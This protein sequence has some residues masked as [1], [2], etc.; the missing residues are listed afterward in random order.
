MVYAPQN[1]LIV[2]SDRSLL[3]EVDNPL[4]ASARDDLARFAELEKSPEHIHTY[5]IT[6]LSL[7][8]AASAGLTPEAA[9]DILGKYS[10]FDLPGNVLI[11]IKDYINRFGRLKLTKSPEGDL[12]LKSED[13]MLISEVSRNKRIAPHAVGDRRRRAQRERWSRSTPPITIR[14]GMMKRPAPAG[15]GPSTRRPCLAARPRGQL[16]GRE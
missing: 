16:H 12:L 4:Y 5:R 11:D 13:P 2:Q 10:K 3:L 14:A 15:S 1:P 8:N 7:W 6:P 9:V